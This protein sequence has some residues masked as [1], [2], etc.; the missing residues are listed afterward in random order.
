MIIKIFHTEL[1]DAEIQFDDNNEKSEI[2]DSSATWIV[3]YVPE[4]VEILFEPFG[5]TPKLWI[6]NFLINFWLADV[7]QQDHKLIIPIGND[8]FEKYRIRDGQGRLQSLGVNPDPILVDKI[9]GRNFHQLLV[10]DIKLKLDEK[11]NLS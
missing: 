11:R 9:V 4:S 5:I 7:Q 10:D 3:P 8:F 1:R 2:K 6:D